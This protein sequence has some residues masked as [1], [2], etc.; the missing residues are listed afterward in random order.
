MLLRSVRTGVYVTF[1]IL[2][3]GSLEVV[4]LPAN[5]DPA[6]PDSLIL[7]QR[8]VSFEH[9]NQELVLKC[10]VGMLVIKPYADNIAH[11]RYFPTLKRAASPPGVISA[12]PAVPKYRAESTLSA[13]R[14]VLSQ[15]T[16]S[17]DRKTAQIT[18]LDPKQNVLLASNLYQL[19]SSPGA[20]GDDFSIHA[21]FVAPEDE[22][23]YGLGQHHDGWLD[24]RGRTVNLWHDFQDR[25]G[26]TV[27]IPFLVTNR[28][29]G[30]VFDNAAKTTVTPG[31]DGLTTWDAAAGSALSYYVI[32]GNTADD[33][34]RGYRYLTGTTPLLPKSAFGYIQ[35]KRRYGSQDELLQVARKYR[36][37]GYPLDM[38]VVDGAGGLGAGDLS[39]DEKY[40]PDPDSMNAELGRLGYEAIIACR[41]RF[42][43]ES[44]GFR[45]LQGLN[46]LLKDKD[47][48]VVLNFGLDT[49]GA[50]LDITRTECANWFWDTIR[51]SFSDRG[52][53]GWWLDAD[54]PSHYPSAFPLDEGTGARIRNLYPLMQIRAVYEGHRRDVKERCLVL[55]RSAYLGAQQYG[56]VLRSSDTGPQWDALKR[57]VAT[58]LN[59]GASGLAYWSADIGGGQPSGS[60]VGPEA[61]EY[62]ELYARWFEFGAFC[63]IFLAHSSRA[64]NEVWSYGDAAEKILVK[65]LRLRYRLL[66]YIYSLARK[67]TETGAPFMRA[68]FMDFPQD[69]EVRDLRDEYMFGPAFLV[70]PVVEKGKT[71]RDVYLPRGAV[72][73]DYWT[74]RKYAGGQRIFA[75]APLDV[76]PLFVKAGSIIPHGNDIP[77]TRSEQREVELHVY[78]GAD[79][80]F[81]LYQDDGR[82]YT[83]ETGRFS[84]A[85]IRWNDAAQKITITG[86]DRKLFAR[87]QDKW[88]KIVK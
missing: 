28:K 45:A 63:P 49:G 35:G 64:E 7:P 73:Y 32:C 66:P 77:N 54:E 72:W 51:K 14:L 53:T 76:L 78:A 67:V 11:V 36:Q 17:V 20:G 65:Y 61:A 31:K 6:S 16:V 43:Q 52:F 25:V 10:T 4:S 59:V 71:G 40:W 57:Q 2:A 5:Q 47:G 1:V 3:L 29:Y 15:L 27:A 74:G 55:A 34:Y 88:L 13:I 70:A 24:Q 86:D 26:E 50:L 38:L 81:D 8:V 62:A 48:K 85:Q 69:L 39:L 60:G 75:D 33:I 87:P 19:R 56:T 79:G 41:P 23:Y 12:T 42:E 83:Y 82:T 37:K 30:F 9:V 18:F 44:P 22:A 46:C 21:E 80:Q 68:L 84:L 58:A